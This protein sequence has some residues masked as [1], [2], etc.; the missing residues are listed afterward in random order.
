MRKAQAEQAQSRSSRTPQT[1]SPASV[2]FPLSQQALLALGSVVGNRAAGRLATDPQLSVDRD[3]SVAAKALDLGGLASKVGPATIG[4][5]VNPVAPPASGD[6]NASTSSD[7]ETRNAILESV[8]RLA[9][10]GNAD[11]DWKSPIEEVKERNKGWLAAKFERS[12]FIELPFGESW[13]TNATD[14]SVT[15]ALLNHLFEGKARGP[16]TFARLRNALD[17]RSYGGSAAAAGDDR[18][19]RANLRGILAADPTAKTLKYHI[20]PGTLRVIEE[21]YRRLRTFEVKRGEEIYQIAAAETGQMVGDFYRAHANGLVRLANGAMSISTEIPRR[22]GIIDAAP[23]IPELDMESQWGKDNKRTLE[24]GVDLGLLLVGGGMAAGTKATIAG[25]STRLSSISVGGLNVGPWLDAAA[26]AYFTIGGVSSIEVVATQAR[27]AIELIAYEEVEDPKTGVTRPATEAEMLDAWKQ[28]FDV[29][30][31]FTKDAVV[32]RRAKQNARREAEAATHLEESATGGRDLVDDAPESTTTRDGDA[33]AAP[34]RDRAEGTDATPVEVAAPRS[35]PADSAVESTTAPAAPTLGSGRASGKGKAKAKAPNHRR[36][37]HEGEGRSW[38]RFGELLA[39]ADID[40]VRKKIND[41]DYGATKEQKAQVLREFEVARLNQI[42]MTEGTVAATILEQPT[43]RVRDGKRSYSDATH[44]VSY[45]DVGSKGFLSDRDRMVTVEYSDPV[46]NNLAREFPEAAATLAKKSIEIV[47]ASNKKLDE[48]A[49][50]SAETALDTNYY[51]DLHEERFVP[52]TPAERSAVVLDQ[53][54]A[55]LTVQKMRMPPSEWNRHLQ[56]LVEGLDEATAKKIQDKINQAEVRAPALKAKGLSKAYAELTAAL[57]KKPLDIVEIRR[58]ATDVKLLEPDAYGVRDAVLETRAS[59][60]LSKLGKE[61]P[62]EGST[63]KRELVAAAAANVTRGSDATSMKAQAHRA[64][65][66]YADLTKKID[67][68]GSGNTLPQVAA[69]AKH[70]LRIFDSVENAGLVDPKIAGMVATLGKI[71]EA[72]KVGEDAGASMAHK[73]IDKWL[74]DATGPEPD[75][76]DPKMSQQAAFDTFSNEASR[77]GGDA[78][79]RL[80]RLD[81]TAS[82]E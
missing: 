50:A 44:E 64:A 79:R 56:L 43:L 69:A 60:Q 42:E 36:L 1:T 76:I 80:T 16:N 78:S 30:S 27:D 2:A 65:Q 71:V 13:A 58:L 67:P 19:L 39:I 12:E 31:G 72:K 20:K 6:E 57:S 38:E 48:T 7:D 68:S 37:A 11:D 34:P 22:L 4:L 53:D 63:P 14:A 29:A 9:G 8:A 18:A 17:I 52:N 5:R 28:L 15:Y 33:D 23:Q 45:D 40:K 81:E 74:R 55:A 62:G 59:Q 41:G 82:E 49:G 32:N 47:V 51:S 75:W 46:L 25:A 66:H 61:T 10:G 54:V 77:L 73:A 70:L 24:I 26:K 3:T 21:A 35:R